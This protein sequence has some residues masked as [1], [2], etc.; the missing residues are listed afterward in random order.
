MV[1]QN[2]I[3]NLP[4]K[5]PTYLDRATL[6]IFNFLIVRIMKDDPEHASHETILLK[7][8][9]KSTLFFMLLAFLVKLA[10]FISLLYIK[11]N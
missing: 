4:P 9:I 8:M 7:F 3:A 2:R 10:F 1:E 11:F 5:K 6:A